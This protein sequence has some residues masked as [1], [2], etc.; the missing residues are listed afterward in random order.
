MVRA[1]DKSLEN[2]PGLSILGSDRPKRQSFAHFRG[3]PY[4]IFVDNL[5][6]RVPRGVEKGID[7]RMAK[8]LN[9]SDGFLNGAIRDR[10]Q[11]QNPNG[12]W[13]KRDTETGKFLNVK[14]DETPF[15]GVRREK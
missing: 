2:R 11:V 14:H 4:S 5:C 6:P 12:H 8:N 10:S 13:I 15:K 9:K 3:P 1:Q 7:T